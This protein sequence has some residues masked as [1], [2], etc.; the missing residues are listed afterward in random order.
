MTVVLQMTR[1]ER[2]HPLPELWN[3][4][5][6]ARTAMYEPNQHHDREVVRPANE[7]KVTACPLRRNL[8]P[9]YGC[10][11]LAELTHPYRRPVASRLAPSD[12]EAKSAERGSK[13]V[14][15]HRGRCRRS[16]ASDP[17]PG[18]ILPPASPAVRRRAAPNAG[19]SEL[20]SAADAAVGRRPR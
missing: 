20:A 13:R 5:G 16:K 7:S 6:K 12:S 9:H 2:P 8:D 17:I 4:F 14:R 3:L 18:V 1:D 19:R 15:R 10:R 11:L